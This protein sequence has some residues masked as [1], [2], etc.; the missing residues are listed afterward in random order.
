MNEQSLLKSGEAV[1]YTF[2][3]AFTC[4][5]LKHFMSHFSSAFAARCRFADISATPA[6]DNLSLA[7]AAAAT[8]YSDCFMVDT[9]YRKRVFLFYYLTIMAVA[10]PAN[11][12]SLFVAWKHIRQGNELGV[13][14]FNLALSDLSFTLG[15]VAWLESMWR[16]MWVH[17][18]ELCM[19]SLNLLLT[20]FYTTEALLCCISV[21]RYLAVVHPFKYRHLR[22]VRTAAAVSLA[23][24]ALVI[25]FNVA[26][27]TQED[28]YH[29]YEDF[30]VCLSVFLPMSE[31]VARTTVAR[32]CLGFIVPVALVVFCCWRIGLT[33][34]SNQATDEQERRRVTRLMVVILFWLVVCFGPVHVV[35]LLQMLADDCQ[36][37]LWL[38]Y[39]DKITVAVAS[40]N[41]IADPVI[42]C[43]ATA[44]GM[45]NIKRMLL[46]CRAKSGGTE[47]S[48]DPAESS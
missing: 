48:E 5:F 45:V 22:R 44:T 12:F 27:V 7:T 3:K 11:A 20:N 40:L 9:T 6:A 2:N 42:Y 25:C 32:F 41:C 26:T 18:P 8:N 21:D 29:Q 24:W 17:G 28:S 36:S 33:V 46:F 4:T 15:L 10:I 14:L 38:L 39:L 47:G 30:A 23:V 43:F 19:L 34:K 31:H 13:Y 16:G 1:Y 35:Q 37:A